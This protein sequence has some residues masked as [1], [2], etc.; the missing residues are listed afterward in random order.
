[1]P[2]DPRKHEQMNDDH[3]ASLLAEIRDNQRQALEQQ[4]AQLEIA[5]SHFEHAKAQIAESLK[6]QKEA[7]SRARTATRV[8]LPAL[9]LCIAAIVYLMWRYF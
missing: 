4:R 2:E 5:H 8:A 1:M 6:L 7:V 9:L 3:I